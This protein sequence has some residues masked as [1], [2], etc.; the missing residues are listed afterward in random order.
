MF[1]FSFNFT[2]II[3]YYTVALD[4]DTLKTNYKS[5]FASHVL[6]GCLFCMEL[7]FM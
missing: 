2:K 3:T 1:F 4:K 6:A 5:I 7:N